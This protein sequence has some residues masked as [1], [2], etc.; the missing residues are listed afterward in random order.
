MSPVERNDPTLAETDLASRVCASCPPESASTPSAK[1]RCF[2]LTLAYD[3]T[4]YFGWQRQPDHPTVQAAVEAALCELTGEPQIT[5]LASSRTDT[6]VHALGQSVVFKTT[7]WPAAAERLPLA[8]NTKLPRDIVAREAVE[9]AT[10]FNPLRESTGKRYCYQVYASRKADPINARTHWWVRR[11]ISLEPM[12]AAA[13]QI[14]GEHDFASFQTTGSP[15]ES[16]VRVV[17]ELR[18]ES[19]P[20]MDGTL[21]HIHIEANGFLYNMVRN[22]VGTLVQVGV[23]KHPPG[24][25]TQV[26]AAKDRRL[27]GPTAPP[28]GLALLEVKY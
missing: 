1:L 19:R 24:W 2:R 25:V 28:H 27:A 26:L 3:G 10:S 14:V 4:H 18:I 12:L 11:R 7:G 22:I 23:E 20:H 17:R 13:E 16:T 9:V 15:R 5:A 21:Y 8:L 6:G